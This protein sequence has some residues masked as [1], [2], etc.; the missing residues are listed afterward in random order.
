[1]LEELARTEL[2]E[3]V[4]KAR[5]EMLAVEEDIASWG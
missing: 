4:E 1:L 2:K 5:S 3:E